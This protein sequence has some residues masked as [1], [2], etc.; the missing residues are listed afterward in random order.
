MRDFSMTPGTR[1]G[2]RDWA[3]AAYHLLVLVPPKS[4]ALS[5]HSVSI[6]LPEAW[7]R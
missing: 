7:D 2:S 1:W 4:L 3:A 5:K 6:L